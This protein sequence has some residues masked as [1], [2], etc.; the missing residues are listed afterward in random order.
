MNVAASLANITLNQLNFTANCSNL[1]LGLY[2]FE[3]DFNLPSP[4]PGNYKYDND[5]Y[6]NSTVDDGPSEYFEDFWINGTSP[7]WISFW[8]FTLSSVLPNDYLRL[9][10]ADI[11]RWANTT[12]CTLW[13]GT[14]LSYRPH[15]VSQVFVSHSRCLIACLSTLKKQS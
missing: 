8:R 12:V 10:D 3:N 2:V 13:E 11:A 4:T 14:F 15:V 5:S 7:E 6:Y 9:S 1:A